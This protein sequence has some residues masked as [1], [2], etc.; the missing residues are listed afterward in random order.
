MVEENKW[1]GVETT[2]FVSKRMCRNVALEKKR[3]GA[4]PLVA[5]KRTD[6]EGDN[7][8]LSSRWKRND[9]EGDS[10]SLSSRW[11][12]ND[13]EGDS[14]SLSSR[15]KRNDE[16]GTAPPHRGVAKNETT[17]KEGDCPSLLSR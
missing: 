8:P 14:L 17:D 3:R 13:E 6:Q 5:L 12:R 11:K 16:E 4:V 15:W 10:P 7:P 2:P 9:E 1:G